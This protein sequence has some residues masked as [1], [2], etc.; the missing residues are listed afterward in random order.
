M[1]WVRAPFAAELNVVSAVPLFRVFNS[2]NPGPEERAARIDGGLTPPANS[3]KSDCM[4]KVRS[5]TEGVEVEDMARA[6]IENVASLPI[7][8]GVAVMPD[9]HWGMGATVGTV[10]AT[11]QA[12]IPAAVGVDIGCGMAAVRLSLAASDLPESLK[13]V[14]AQIERDV[15]VG[16]EE[17]KENRLAVSRETIERL[18]ASGLSW[19]REAHPSIVQRDPGKVWRQLGTL[20]GGNHFVE[21][22]LD[23]EQRVWVLLHSGSRNIG[24]VVADYF[25][26][27]AK[28]RAERLGLELPD[29]DLAYL[30]AGESDFAD[31]IQAVSWAQSYAAENRRTMLA[32]VLRGLASMKGFPPFTATEQAI[33]CHHNYIAQEGP[34]LITRKGAIRA[35]QGELG[36]IP[37]SMGTRSYIVRGRGCAASFESCSH[38]AGRR[39]SRGAARKKFTRE[40]HELATAGVECRKDK[41]VIDETPGAY[42]D[43]DAVMAAQTELVEVVHT[44]KQVLCVKG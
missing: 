42:K 28:A 37:G 8:H 17:H 41:D 15:P 29:K 25:I 5:W 30:V 16:F 11:T 12:V 40:D 27:K 38:G 9:V 39:M 20:G 24:K 31:Y 34:F 10:I 7:V 35:G 26:T 1:A 22:C 14:R 21:L 6:Q 33:N 23:E 43:I 3:R 18:T 13:A 32:Q 2:R 19:M 36:I 4:S 44:L